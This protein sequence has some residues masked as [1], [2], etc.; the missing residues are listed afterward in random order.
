MKK[1][2]S[3]RFGSFFSRVETEREVLGIINARYGHRAALNGLSEAAINHWKGRIVGLEICSDQSIGKVLDLLCRISVRSDAQADQS[4]V[5]FADE[6]SHALPI[7]ELV[8]ALRGTCA[9]RQELQAD[10]T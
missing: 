5:V 9:S 2:P 8:S 3:N 1:S 10:R 4:R 6:P 7:S